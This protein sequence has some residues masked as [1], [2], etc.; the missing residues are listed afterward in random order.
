MTWD[1]FV[2]VRRFNNVGPTQQP[3]SQEGENLGRPDLAAEP[4]SSRM[5]PVQEP[6]PVEKSP[7]KE[8]LVELVKASIGI[9]SQTLM[10]TRDAV[11]REKGKEKQSDMKKKKEKGKNID[12][13][14]PVTKKRKIAE[15]S[16]PAAT[17][18][19]TKTP[20]EMEIENPLGATKEM[21]LKRSHRLQGKP[22]NKRQS[23]KPSASIFVDSPKW[24]PSSPSQDVILPTL[25]VKP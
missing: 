23:E 15:E 24:E 3:P 11:Q 10:R 13:V 6:P 1:E 5:S 18:V 8:T 17:V 25:I 12:L 14:S 16:S 22:K 4:S 21:P 20:K 2:R 9:L 7:P 19:A